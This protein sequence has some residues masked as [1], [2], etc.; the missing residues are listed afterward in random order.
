MNTLPYT[1]AL[2][3]PQNDWH[4]DAKRRVAQRGPAILQELGP[5]KRGHSYQSWH[6]AHHPGT[7]PGWAG[8]RYRKAPKVP[9]ASSVEPA[10]HESAADE[11]NAAR[12]SRTAGI[13]VRFHPRIKIR[14]ADLR[15]FPRITRAASRRHR[16]A[17]TRPVGAGVGRIPRAARPDPNP[18]QEG[19]GCLP[20]YVGVMFVAPYPA[21]P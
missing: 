20:E 18:P 16:E 6:S 21:Q 1:Q 12:P 7:M 11:G 15:L 4:L 2:Q 8:T 17:S 5:S 3:I 9:S 13:P 19:R 14:M 10:P